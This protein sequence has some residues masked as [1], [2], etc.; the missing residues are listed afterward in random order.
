MPQTNVVYKQVNSNLAQKYKDPLFNPVYQEAFPAMEVPFELGKGRKKT[1]RAYREQIEGFSSKFSVARSVN[2]TDELYDYS[3]DWE[4]DA[5]E[6]SLA[7]LG[8]YANRG[9]TSQKQMKDEEREIMSTRF[10][11]KKQR[12]L[13]TY[14]SDNNNFAGATHYANAG[15]QWSNW[16]TASP[17]D[18]VWIG[19]QQV[20]RANAIIMGDE[21]YYNCLANQ[22][23]NAS[24]QGSGVVKGSIDPRIGV[25][26]L[27]RYFRVEYLWIAGGE[28]ITNSAD[29]TDET[30]VDIWGNKV[31][32][33]HHDP[34]PRVASDTWMK[35][36]FFRPGDPKRGEPTEGWRII[37]KETEEEGG[38]GI[39]KEAL[40]NN[41]DYLKQN[42]KLAYRIDLT[43]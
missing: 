5:F 25:D 36:I 22:T 39:Y 8:Q 2:T 15:V 37:V 1:E 18:D 23:I 30:T 38:I 24:V 13:Y 17:G 42:T 32:I 12:A 11:K 43:H 40:W 29:R 4:S 34:N 7:D 21:D 28:I 31:L 27:K 10:K 6:F 9:F 35:Q 16:G 19:L 41:Y 20:K 3:T 33:F 26:F 14:V